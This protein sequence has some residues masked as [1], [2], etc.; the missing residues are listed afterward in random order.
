MKSTIGGA[1]PRLNKLLPLLVAAATFL[2]FLPSLE[3]QFVNW[4][5]HAN[6]LENPH[7]RGFTFENLRWMLTSF[8]LGHYQPLSWLSYALDH[9]V[10][11]LHPFGYHLTN[12]LLH[13]ANSVL[14]LLLAETILGASPWLALTTLLFS[15]H[16]LRV[17]S[18]A[19]AT[20]RRDV[21]SAFFYLSA[22]LLYL[23][24]A[25]LPEGR[26]R[27]RLLAACWCCGF[28]ALSAK[29]TSLTLPLVL[30]LL[31]IYPLRRMSAKVRFEILPVAF[32]ALFAGIIGLLAQA[33]GPALAG[34]ADRSMSER[35]LQ[36]LL[37]PSFYLLKSLFPLDLSPW[38]GT[39]LLAENAAAGAWATAALTALAW[40]KRRRH[41][42]LASAW[43]LYLTL[44][45]PTLGLVQS[46]RQIAADRFTYLPSVV[47]ALTAGAGLKAAFS[48]PITSLTR[49]ALAASV[50]TIAGVLGALTWNQ[51]RLWN[52]TISL[53]SHALAVDPLPD[54]PHI[55]LAAGL[56]D[57]ERTE[58]AVLLLEQRLRES[59][60]FVVT[61]AL[62]RALH[63][64]GVELAL[65]G[66]PQ[67]AISRWERALNLDPGLDVTRQA[68][69]GIKRARS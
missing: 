2:A 55:N 23:R 14:V 22:V 54:S 25:A 64:R 31:N 62:A 26:R 44:L 13:C 63:N 53:W 69:R 8:H 12:V 59:P 11:G 56:L 49:R 21:L 60:S 45:F 27:S 6:L 24:V 38:Y 36:S 35:L 3:N 34:F 58:E 15:L 28:L 65:D 67:E 1:L 47:L 19:W 50:L 5:D 40:T 68:L 37:A 30:L 17:E 39:S 32:L 41:P 20:E 48:A 16:P 18:V 43:V 7:F 61:Q 46:G 52:N 42:E 57:A 51:C 29:V 33:D 10:W 9:A 4:D 66:R